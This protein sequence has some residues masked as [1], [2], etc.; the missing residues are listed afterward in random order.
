MLDVDELK[1]LVKKKNAGEIANYIKKYSLDIV[2]N[3]IKGNPRVCKSLTDYWDKRQ[4][5]KKINLNSL[6]IGRVCQ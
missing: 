2:D 5:V 6:D 1:L 4:L 3:K